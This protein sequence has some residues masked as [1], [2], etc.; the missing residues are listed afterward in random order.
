M[1]TNPRNLLVNTLINHLYTGLATGFTPAG[2]S[3]V[4]ASTKF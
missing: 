2:D 3:I 1:L 4:K